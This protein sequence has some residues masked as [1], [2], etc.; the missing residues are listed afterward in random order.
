MATGT[1][2][3]ATAPA[4]AS[5]LICCRRSPWARRNR[6]ITDATEPDHP[7]QHQED[8]ERGERAEQRAVG[9]EGL[10]IDG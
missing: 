1:T 4:S 5:H 10:S 2:T 6:T 3:A 8:R 7:D 9:A